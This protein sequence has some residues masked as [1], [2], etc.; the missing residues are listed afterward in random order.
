MPEI[1]VNDNQ[2]INKLVEYATERDKSRRIMATGVYPNS[3]A[4][5][6]A[7]NEFLLWLAANPDY[8]D[9]HATSTAAVTAYITQM[10]QAMQTIITIMESIERA[11][12]GTFGI[13]LP[14]VEEQPE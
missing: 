5:M 6:R 2:S 8:V 7:Y 4:A 3:V 13:Q 1:I 10:Q 12:P 9:L 14:V 11:Y